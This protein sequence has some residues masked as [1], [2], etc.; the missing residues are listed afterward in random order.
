MPS[1][2]I[3]DDERDLVSLLDFNLRQA[4][5]QTRVASAG[6]DALADKVIKTGDTLFGQTV[7]S[8]EFY[9]SNAFNNGGQVLF[10]YAFSNGVEGFAVATP[11]PATASWIKDDSVSLWSAAGS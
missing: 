4:G 1:I 3:V 7:A 8:I 6:A 11:V 5:F 2:L 9:R 10:N